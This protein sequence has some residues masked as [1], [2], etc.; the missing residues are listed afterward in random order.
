[1]AIRDQLGEDQ[2]LWI[3]YAKQAQSIWELYPWR[4]CDEIGL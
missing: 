1:M 3:Y 2:K 4:I